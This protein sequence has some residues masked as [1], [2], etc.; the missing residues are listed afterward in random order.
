MEGAL[1]ALRRTLRSERARLSR[2]YNKSC[3]YFW[4]PI[5][6]PII[7]KTTLGWQLRAKNYI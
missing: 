4:C 7:G 5:L 2:P 1:G 3:N 6:I